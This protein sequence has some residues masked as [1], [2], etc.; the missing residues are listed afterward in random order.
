MKL[1]KWGMFWF[2]HWIYN[3]TPVLGCLKFGGFKSQD[4]QELCNFIA[5]YGRTTYQKKHS[6]S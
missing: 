6:I 5:G 2:W 4:A 1:G 3:I